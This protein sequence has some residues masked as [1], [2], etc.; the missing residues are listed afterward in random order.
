MMK[1]LLCILVC[2]FP[3]L[4]VAQSPFDGT[5]KTNMSQ[6]KLSQKPYE[7]SV[8]NGMYDCESCAPKLNNIKADGQDQAVS[9]QSYDAIA[10]KVVSPT[11]IQVTTKKNG[12]TAGESTRT[13]SPDGKTLTIM[14]TNYPPDGKPYKYEV[15]FMRVSNGPADS[16]KTSGS[17]RVQTVNEETPGITMTFMITG[18]EVKYSGGAGESWTAKFGGPEVPVKGVYGDETVSVKKLSSH[19]IEVTIKRDGK[20]FSVNKITV[21]P[22]DK[23]MI[24]VYDN[25]QTGRVSTYVDEK[26]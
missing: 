26:Q 19:S 1:K 25:K 10:V 21:S 23:K 8:Q 14:G 20:L 12:K 6:S 9:G 11:E 13:V 24:E 15:K 18:D 2:L 7:F 5:W 16:N 22:G 3:A 4:L 17:W